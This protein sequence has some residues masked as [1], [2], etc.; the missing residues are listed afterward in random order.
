VSDGGGLDTTRRVFFAVGALLVVVGLLVLGW[1]MPRLD[2]ALTS[3]G[4]AYAV[5]VALPIATLGASMLLQAAGDGAS[6]GGTTVSRGRGRVGVQGSWS[7]TT[8]SPAP[9]I[10]SFAG[11]LALLLVVVT[12]L[13]AFGPVLAVVGVVVAG[14]MA[15]WGRLALLAWRRRR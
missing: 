10:C 7:L 5:I 12:H 13:D 6:S 1:A 8:T 9:A 11:A 2:A 3:P 15:N 14:F 4:A